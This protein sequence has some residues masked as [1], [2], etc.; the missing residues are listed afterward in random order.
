MIIVNERQVKAMDYN[1][2][3]ETVEMNCIKISS[4]LY[5][6]ARFYDLSKWTVGAAVE[7]F[8]EDELTE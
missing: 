4:V 3:I 1:I 7:N 5:G 2:T 6:I 8:I